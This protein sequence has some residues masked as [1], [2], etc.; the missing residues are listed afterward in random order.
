MNFSVR[1][2]DRE[3][4]MAL[5]V[6]KTDAMFTRYNVVNA[7]RLLKR[8]AQLTPTTNGNLPATLEGTA[9]PA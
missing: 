4:I 3:E 7:A 2:F 6:W 1:D 5:C 8:A 9:P